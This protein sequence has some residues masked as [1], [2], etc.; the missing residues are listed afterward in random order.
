MDDEEEGRSSRAFKERKRYSSN[1]VVRHGP[2]RTFRIRST[3]QG[4]AVGT[5]QSLQNHVSLV[6]PPK[7]GGSVH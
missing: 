5:S 2:A 6:L 1:A 4:T 7:M 3:E